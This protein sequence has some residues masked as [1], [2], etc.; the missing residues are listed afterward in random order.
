M[1]DAKDDWRFLFPVFREIYEKDKS[2]GPEREYLDTIMAGLQK[3]FPTITNAP[4]P[5]LEAGHEPPR[6]LEKK[7]SQSPRQQ[8]PKPAL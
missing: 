7:P 6:K 2:K 8:P 4:V 1:Y 5:R 3:W